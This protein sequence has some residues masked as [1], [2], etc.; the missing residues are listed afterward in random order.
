MSFIVQNWRDEVSVCFPDRA[1]RLNTGHLVTLNF[2][3]IVNIFKPM[4]QLFA[5]IQPSLIP[6]ILGDSGYHGAYDL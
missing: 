1:V 4:S 6:S 3:Y 2:R 5:F